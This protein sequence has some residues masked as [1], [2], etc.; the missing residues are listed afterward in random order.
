MTSTIGFNLIIKHYTVPSEIIKLYR[1]IKLSKFFLSFSLV[2]V[3]FCWQTMITHKRY[4]NFNRVFLYK[5]YLLEWEEA[6]SIPLMWLYSQK[7][8]FTLFQLATKRSN[9]FN[10]I[11]NKKK[12]VLIWCELLLYNDVSIFYW[13]CYTAIFFIY[14]LTGNEIITQARSVICVVWVNV[15]IK[16]RENFVKIGASRKRFDLLVCFIFFEICHVFVNNI[17]R[18]TTIECIIK[19]KQICEKERKENVSINLRLI[20]LH[21][22]VI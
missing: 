8:N 13:T 12:N 10:R 4:V 7:C 16:K 11:F 2:K 3:K 5:K 20:N 18:T 22:V 1:I 6:H 15:N 21:L 9:L 19:N 14:Y 17:T